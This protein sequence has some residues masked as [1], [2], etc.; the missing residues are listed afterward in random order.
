V[1]IG[2]IHQI[3]AFQTDWDIRL[4]C[5]NKYSERATER[6]DP[7]NWWSPFL[8]LPLLGR[9]E[10]KRRENPSS[11]TGPYQVEKGGNPSCTAE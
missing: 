11:S 9:A 5:E 1:Q 8:P 2:K 3:E 7:R 6:R 10:K 4:K